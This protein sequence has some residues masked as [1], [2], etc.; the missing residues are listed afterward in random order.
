MRSFLFICLQ[1]KS[2]TPCSEDIRL[3]DSCLFDVCFVDARPPICSSHVNK[4]V[5]N[6]NHAKTPVS[7]LNLLNLDYI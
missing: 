1:L 6:I 3:E 5:S 2:G 4:T 7:T